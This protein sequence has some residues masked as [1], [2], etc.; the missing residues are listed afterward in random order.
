MTGPREAPDGRNG[1]NGGDPVP[2]QVTFTSELFVP[3]EQAEFLSRLSGKRAFVTGSS[4][5]IGAEIAFAL[6][7]E[8]ADVT[9]VHRSEQYEKRQNRVAQRIE[10][11]G[12]NFTSHLADLST[13]EGREIAMNG[14]IV[15]PE[16]PQML[17]ILVIN[18]AGGLEPDMPDDYAEKINVES[19]R[20]LVNGLLPFMN[21][22][23]II[24]YITSY[25]AHKKDDPTV[26]QLP[27]YFPVA[28]TKFAAE[29]ELR[30]RS[31]ELSEKNIKIGVVVGHVVTD[32]GAFPIFNMVAKEEIDRLRPLAQGGEFPS[33]EQMGIATRDLVVS[34]STSEDL[35]T[36]HTVY[37]G[38]TDVEK[39]DPTKQIVLDRE[40]V[41]A[42]LPM[43][44]DDRLYI[45][46]F[47]L[48]ED[49]Q[50][51]HGT[52]TVRHSDVEGHFTGEYE[53]IQL[54]RGFDRA[55]A[56]AQMGGLTYKVARDMKRGAGYLIGTGQT[57]FPEAVFE[58]ET[59]DM[60]VRITAENRRG[61]T[62]DGE[63]RVGEK[64][65]ATVKELTIGLTPNVDLIR[66]TLRKTKKRR[67]ESRQNQSSQTEQQQ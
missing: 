33:A 37:V 62:V 35:E 43:Y 51:G 64:I 66:G 34:L 15:D 45:D 29:Q 57:R 30:G 59:V 47:E 20:D 21:E 19:P 65:V 36:G 56:L 2:P 58:G 8:G 61:I 41:K 50:G 55:E 46:T 67:E 48:S 40:G 28:S 63:M 38:G 17:D 7:A 42:E 6:A 49:R 39:I 27:M 4:R 11:V 16:N 60:D 53:D 3:T 9:G 26:K 13:P 32:T 54:S 10:A 25:W 1:G 52:Y 24:I 12:G 22:G 31:S 23:G 44:G 5:G 14:A 18:A